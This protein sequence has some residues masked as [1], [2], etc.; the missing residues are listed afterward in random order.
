RILLAHALATPPERLTLLLREPL[1]PGADAALGPLLAA[2]AARQPVA[3]IIGHRLFWGRRFRVTRD[4]LDPR[5]ETE[6]L[7]ACALAAPFSQVLDL[8]TGTGAILLTLL[9]ERR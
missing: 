7:I 1:P 9:A 6:T 3:Q 8:G 5:P 4:T 2:R